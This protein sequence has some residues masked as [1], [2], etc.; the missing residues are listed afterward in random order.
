MKEKPRE[1]LW[2]HATTGVDL[3]KSSCVRTWTRRRLQAAVVQQLK[4]R[5][6][7]K[8][9]KLL[10]RRRMKSDDDLSTPMPPDPSYDLKGSLRLHVQAPLIPAKFE[11][12][13]DEVGTILDIIVAGVNAQG[14]VPL[15]DS[16]KPSHRP[17]WNPPQDRGKQTR[18]TQH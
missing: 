15:I 2:W 12:I 16:K 7:D 10:S 6:Y 11:E 13:K 17:L 4:A 9:G 8:N 14:D 1:G 18:T 5:G 3:V